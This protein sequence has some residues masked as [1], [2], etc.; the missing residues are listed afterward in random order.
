MI[1]FEFY[2]ECAVGIAIVLAVLVA[3]GIFERHFLSRPVVYHI[4]MLL[5][6]FLMNNAA[7]VILV[8]WMSTEWYVIASHIVNILSLAIYIRGHIFPIYLDL[9]EK[10]SGY[11]PL[12]AAK[13]LIF[14]GFFGVCLYTFLSVCVYC[15]ASL[16]EAE[17]Q[18]YEHHPCD[19]SGIEYSIMFIMLVIMAVLAGLLMT[20]GCIRY[21][22]TTDWKKGKKALFIILTFIPIFNVVY[23]VMCLKKISQKV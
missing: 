10:Y 21:I 1:V 22:L 20:N 15:Y 13:S 2:S 8:E 11:R 4:S 6:I 17:N 5:S 23:G 19:M 18:Y 14:T 9:E 3:I 12:Y 16:L 7:L